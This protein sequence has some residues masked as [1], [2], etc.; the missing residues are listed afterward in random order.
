MNDD[1]YKALQDIGK[2]AAESIAEMVAALE[3]DYGRLEE[4]RD[5]ESDDLEQGEVDE[6]TELEK[7]AGDC[8]D[9]EDA[10]Q[11]I[12][13]SP[14]EVT[15]RGDWVPFGTEPVDAHSWHRACHQRAAQMSARPAAQTCKTCNGSGE[16]SMVSKTYAVMPM[17]TCM[18]CDGT[19]KQID[20]LEPYV[21]PERLANGRDA[22]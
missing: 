13:E 3:C 8:T 20:S 22:I 15:M 10:E 9:R 16:V 19:G 14:L 5:T 6:M 2:S 11:R 1:K 12:Q 18:N 17:I 21:S 7:A 4:L